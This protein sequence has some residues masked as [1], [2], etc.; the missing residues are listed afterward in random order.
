MATRPIIWRVFPS[1][2]ALDPAR[3]MVVWSARQT[4]GTLLWTATY[5][6]EPYD[7]AHTTAKSAMS[8]ASY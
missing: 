4:D 3:E 2:T 5:G 7:C 1:P 6:S 8:D